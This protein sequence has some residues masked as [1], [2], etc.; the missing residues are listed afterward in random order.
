MRIHRRMCGT[1]ERT[2]RVRA[3]RTIGAGLAITV[4]TLAVVRM[5]P[6]PPAV[7]PGSLQQILRLCGSVIWIGSLAVGLELTLAGLFGLAWPRRF[8]VGRG[9]HRDQNRTTLMWN[10]THEDG[11]RIHC[12]LRGVWPDGHCFAERHLTFDFND[13]DPLRYGWAAAGEFTREETQAIFDFVQ[14]AAAYPDRARLVEGE[15]VSG[16]GVVGRGP[17]STPEIL[18]R[19]IPGR[20]TE[21]DASFL[22]LVARL[23]ASKLL[24][25]M[26]RPVVRR[27]AARRRGRQLR[28]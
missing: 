4:A 23:E 3:L 28:E 25:R 21:L 10:R 26:P 16:G 6:A 13:P 9:L 12:R 22:D 20:P 15:R 7:K 24:S 8:V 11:V 27:L 2:V 1:T 19:Y 17:I 18:Y 5:L 14:T